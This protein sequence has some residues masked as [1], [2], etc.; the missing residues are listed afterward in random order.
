MIKKIILGGLVLF[1]IYGALNYSGF[2]FK[3]MRYLSD[4]EKIR[5]AIEFVNEAKVANMRI[6]YDENS[7]KPVRWFKRLPYDKDI[8]SFIADNPD[9][10]QIIPKQRGW[11]DDTPVPSFLHRIAGK[12]NYIVIVK[13]TFRYV[14]GPIVEMP[15]KHAQTS[16]FYYLN[17]SHQGKR[18]TSGPIDG[19]RQQ[20]STLFLTF[21]NCGSYYHYNE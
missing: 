6:H 4:E 15:E 7:G 11:H 1:C 2:C 17:L 19:E 21:G 10:C 5:S 20:Q 13:G 3:K 16:S 14:T 8:A 9:C 12:Y 18:Y